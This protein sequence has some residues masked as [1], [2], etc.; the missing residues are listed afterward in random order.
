[1]SRSS[2]RAMKTFSNWNETQLYQQIT[3][4]DKKAQI[5][6]LRRPKS[7]RNNKKEKFSLFDDLFR[8]S[9]TSIITS[10]VTFDNKTEHGM[11]PVGTYNGYPYQSSIKD[12]INPELEKAINYIKNKVSSFSGYEYLETN[13]PQDRIPLIIDHVRTIEFNLNNDQPPRI[14]SYMNTNYRSL[15]A[16]ECRNSST[17][18]S[19]WFEFDV[20]IPCSVQGT[21]TPQ[22]L[23]EKNETNISSQEGQ[24][25]IISTNHDLMKN[26]FYTW[27]QKKFEENEKE[28]ISTCPPMSI[29]QSYFDKIDTEINKFG[30]YEYNFLGGINSK[31]VPAGI[32]G[33]FISLYNSSKFILDDA[34]AGDPHKN[35]SS[36]RKNMIGFEEIRYKNLDNA[37]ENL[38]RARNEFS[39]IANRLIE[40]AIG[41]KLDGEML[42]RAFF[43]NT[44]RFRRSVISSLLIPR[45]LRNHT[46][47]G[48]IDTLKMM[49][50]LDKDTWINPWNSESVMSNKIDDVSPTSI[51][52]KAYLP[53][54][55]GLSIWNSSWMYPFQTYKC[56]NPGSQTSC[57]KTNLNPGSGYT[58]IADDFMSGGDYSSTL[59][60]K[61]SPVELISNIAAS[62][63]SEAAKSDFKVMYLN[64]E[65]KP[66]T[67]NNY[68]LLTLNPR[69]YGRSKDS[70]Y[71]FLAARRRTHCSTDHVDNT[72][73]R[74]IYS[75]ECRYFDI[76][77]S[78]NNY[79][80]CNGLNGLGELDVQDTWHE[81]SCE[82]NY[83][84]NIWELTK[85][86]GDFRDQ[87]Y[88]NS[89]CVPERRHMF[90]VR[91]TGRV[92]DGGTDAGCSGNPVCG[93]C[94][95]G[96]WTYYDYAYMSEREAR[97][98][99]NDI[100]YTG[101]QGGGKWFDVLKTY[102]DQ[103]GTTRTFGKGTRYS[104]IGNFAKEILRLDSRTA[105]F[106]NSTVAQSKYIA[107]NYIKL[108]E[109]IYKFDDRIMLLWKMYLMK[110]ANEL[111]A[112]LKSEIQSFYTCHPELLLPFRL[113]V[114]Y[115]SFIRSKIFTTAN[116]TGY[117][118]IE[119][120][121]TPH[122]LLSMYDRHTMDKIIHSAI[123]PLNKDTMKIVPYKLGTSDR[124][125]V[126]SLYAAKGNNIGIDAIYQNL[127]ESFAFTFSKTGSQ[128][129]LV[130]PYIKVPDCT[131]PQDYLNKNLF[132]VNAV[133]SEKITELAEKSHAL[134]FDISKI[135]DHAA[136]KFSDSD[137]LNKALKK[138]GT[139]ETVH[140][141]VPIIL[142][143]RQNGV[144]S[145]IY[146]GATTKNNVQMLVCRNESS[147]TTSIGTGTLGSK[148]TT[149][150]LVINKTNI[151]ED[152]RSTAGL[153]SILESVFKYN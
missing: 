28:G 104:C 95:N 107:A 11:T 25:L 140:F 81:N 87:N 121:L 14:R 60:V 143:H 53:M 24:D 42:K 74:D 111:A 85:I 72:G 134:L 127:L 36:L 16:S 71:C 117:Y 88:W 82:H 3:Y 41:N 54:Y 29:Q 21:V 89:V 146:D 119:C 55:N 120:P 136:F 97:R 30:T 124:V 51:P 64:A 138:A 135:C 92:N 20:N 90:K 31:D 94:V 52:S 116:V 2:T 123:N 142:V 84:G 40:G 33:D 10:K 126:H 131:D 45:L 132:E 67:V 128:E 65:K 68:L 133:Q 145:F 70:D 63:V 91:Y 100:N 7:L 1:M 43:D 49:P 8:A 26:A 101:G 76:T 110:H 35:I 118:N 44:G 69:D 27:S 78:S 6:G 48:S 93:S 105:S 102:S 153:P 103:Q 59:S 83:S 125:F 112:K 137:A 17:L 66:L 130:I 109:T 23:S 108:K 61:D 15:D 4:R 151:D 113:N 32:L 147:T 152:L 114:G 122:I 19:E 144:I 13:N 148:A 34:P 79:Q 80:Y 150:Y 139:K 98:N 47:D 77:N 18:N 99:F 22:C 38:T 149:D 57:P 75:W 106:E 56:D 73:P 12:T 62:K 5:S 96:R 86:H 46:F 50:H 58:M 39:T 141:T 9:S 37:A 129:K 115:L